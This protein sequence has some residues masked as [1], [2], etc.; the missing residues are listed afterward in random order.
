MTLQRVCILTC[1]LSAATE[2]EV[3]H[4]KQH[5]EEKIRDVMKFFDVV[6]IEKS[7]KKT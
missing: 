3:C 4:R 1:I 7:L 2:Q 5:V 6:S